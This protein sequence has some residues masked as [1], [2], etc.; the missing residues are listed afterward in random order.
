[1]GFVK[2]RGKVGMKYGVSRLLR[3]GWLLCLLVISVLLVQAQEASLSNAENTPASRELRLKVFEQ[4]WRAINEN[5]YDR[6]FHGLDWLGQ[7]QQYRPQVE[8][9]RDNAEFYRLLRSMIGKLGDAHTRIY[10]PE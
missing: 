8:S 4:V 10:S 7:R 5:Y 2:V 1:M 9:A 6:N 3:C